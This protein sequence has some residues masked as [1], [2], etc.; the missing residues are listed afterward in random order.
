MARIDLDRCYFGDALELSRDLPD[1]FVNCIVT[2]PPYYGLRDY[3]VE[4]QIGW[5]RSPR[6]YAYKLVLIFRELRRALRD[7]GTLWLNLGDCYAGSWGNYAPGGIKGVQRPQT[8]KGKRWDRKAYGEE[9]TKRLPPTRTCLTEMPELKEKDLIGIPWMI[10]FALRGDGWWLR[11]EIVWEKKNPVQESVKDRPSRAHEQ[12]FLFSKSKRYYYD[13][14]AIREPDAENLGTR[15]KR[16]VWT[17]PLFPFAGAHYATF[18]PELIK[19]CIL[20]GCP[21]GGVVLDPFLGS[22]TTGEECQRLGR[23]WI[24]FDLDEKNAPL[25]KERTKQLGLFGKGGG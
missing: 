8:K 1:G 14:E 9:S 6:E 25:I 18:P 11:S 21:E 19:P 13:R 17:V 2:S 16:S 4:G 7:D 22:G 3:G 10:A 20:A 5:E 24:G 23:R 15:D 12:V